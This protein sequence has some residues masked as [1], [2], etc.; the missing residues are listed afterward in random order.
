MAHSALI[1]FLL[2][3]YSVVAAVD[4][5]KWCWLKYERV[6]LFFIFFLHVFARAC[7]NYMQK[8]HEKEFNEKKKKI[9]CVEKKKE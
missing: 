1:T 3:A 8:K 6:C 4:V 2:T 5:R 9:Y 7:E